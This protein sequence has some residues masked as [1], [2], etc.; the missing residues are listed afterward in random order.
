MGISLRKSIKLN[1]RT[2][3]N[4]STGGGIGI[5]TG[6]KGARVSINKNGIR[7]YGGRGIVRFTKHISFKKLFDFINKIFN[8]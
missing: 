7:F 3:L 1:K 2:N 5:S 8:E 4:L 6:V